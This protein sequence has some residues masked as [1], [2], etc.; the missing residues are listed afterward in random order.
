MIVAC[1]KLSIEL[2][3]AGRAQD[4]G[5]LPAPRPSRS[6]PGPG[7]RF[8]L[9]EFQEPQRLNGPDAVEQKPEALRHLPSK[10]MHRKDHWELKLI[11]SIAQ[12][13]RSSPLIT[14]SIQMMTF[15]AF[16]RKQFPNLFS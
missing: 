5:L 10:R 12:A 4:E 16:S 13:V 11:K 9:Q 7:T 2:V 6:V 1:N 15:L 14:S 3:H 8:Q